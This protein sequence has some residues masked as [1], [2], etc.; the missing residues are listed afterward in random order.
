MPKASEAI[1]NY[2]VLGKQDLALISIL[3][4][5]RDGYPNRPKAFPQSVGLIG[6]RDVRD[7][8]G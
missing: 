3:R 5:L 8:I 6:L 7:Y 2:Q 4:Q 1:A